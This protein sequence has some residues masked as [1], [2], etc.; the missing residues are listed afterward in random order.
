MTKIGEMAE[1]VLFLNMQSTLES[2]VGSF[3]R[4]VFL[5]RSPHIETS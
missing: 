2:P 4:S 3:L 5:H 1:N